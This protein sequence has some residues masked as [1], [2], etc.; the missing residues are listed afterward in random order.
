MWATILLHKNI[1]WREISTS[2]G[3]C[4]GEH[5]GLHGH[6]KKELVSYK[7]LLSSTRSSNTIV[8]LSNVLKQAKKIL[9]FDFK[10]EV[11]SFECVLFLQEGPRSSPCQLPMQWTWSKQ[12]LWLMM[13]F[14]TWKSMI[15][16]EVS[17][18]TNIK[19][20]FSFLKML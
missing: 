7:S 6:L 16:V 9:E 4:I 14:L 18:Q 11:G 8:Q 19:D 15:Y 12:F 13:T 17:L 3:T 20:F 2:L 10:R 1:I 5:L